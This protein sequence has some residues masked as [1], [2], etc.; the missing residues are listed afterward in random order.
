MYGNLTAVPQVERASGRIKYVTDVEVR[1]VFIQTQVESI[2]A[3][4]GSEDCITNQRKAGPG[5]NRTETALV[6]HKSLVTLLV[7]QTTSS[8]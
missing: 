8:V 6:N 1:R 2:A 5:L 4:V 7:T 3:V